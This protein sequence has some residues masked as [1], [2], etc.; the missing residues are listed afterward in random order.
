MKIRGRVRVISA[1]GGGG[2]E[3]GQKNYKRETESQTEKTLL[4]KH[5]RDE[6]DYNV[7]AKGEKIETKRAPE[8]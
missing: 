2:G 4:Q 8:K 5:K 3:G 7:K 1:N 6:E